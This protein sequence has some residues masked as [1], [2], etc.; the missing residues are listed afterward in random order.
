MTKTITQINAHIAQL[1][2]E[3]FLE[4]MSEFLTIEQQRTISNC[5]RQIQTLKNEIRAN[6]P[7]WQKKTDAL[8]N[9]V[10]KTCWNSEIRR[11]NYFEEHLSD[12]ITDYANGEHDSLE[13]FLNMLVM[14]FTIS[15]ELV[16]YFTGETLSL[17]DVEDTAT[18]W[19]I[20][21]TPKRKYCNQYTIEIMP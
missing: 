12:F 6:F 3:I 21:R 20:K 4:E 9:L 5:N 14:I 1:K 8:E 10:S 18:I 19:N 11:W 13:D 16:N 17:E 7:K 15:F 2:S